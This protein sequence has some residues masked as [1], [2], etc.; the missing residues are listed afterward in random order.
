MEFYPSRGYAW[1]TPP[2]NDTISSKKTAA[3]S[4][5]S[6]DKNATIINTSKGVLRAQ[7]THMFRRLMDRAIETSSQKI[8]QARQAIDTP[9]PTEDN[10]TLKPSTSSIDLTAS[11]NNRGKEE[12]ERV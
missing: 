4:P 8:M 3:T 5:S 10:N 9:E 7:E 11:Q 1:K 12:L 2:T 6:G